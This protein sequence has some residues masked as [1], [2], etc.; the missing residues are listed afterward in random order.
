MNEKIEIPFNRFKIVN[1][2]F[3]SIVFVVIG[4]SFI[5]EP[6]PFSPPLFQ[7]PIVVQVFG[8]I[9][10][11][12]FGYCLIIIAQKLFNNEVGFIIE[13]KGIINN[14]SGIN[15]GLIE[16]N[17]VSGISHTVLSKSLIL[18]TYEPYKYINRSKNRISRYVMKVN[19]KLFGS[20]LAISPNSLK[21][22]F[23]DFEK[24]IKTEL[25]KRS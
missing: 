12:F 6:K 19:H 20:P 7:S 3:G 9:V 1:H 4:V 10:V 2:L 11:A 24:M 16:W 23:G 25:E 18:K 17:D 15:V 22:K 14:T 8:V 21:I 5:L 13:Q